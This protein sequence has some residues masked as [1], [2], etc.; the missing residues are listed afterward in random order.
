MRNLLIILFSFFLLSGYSQPPLPDWS[1]K[2]PP[3]FLRDAQGRIIT[4]ESGG[5]L[6]VI[7]VDTASAQLV[8]PPDTAQSFEVSLVDIT[9]NLLTTE[10]RGY[11]DFDEA[12]GNAIDSAG[13]ADLTLYGTVTQGETGILGDCYSFAG[14]GNAGNVD[15]YFEFDESF[16]LSVWMKTSS[17][18][19]GGAGLI[20]NFGT[21]NRG[22]D[23]LTWTTASVAK[24][25]IAIRGAWGTVT[26]VG[27]TQVND[28]AWHFI[29]ASYNSD[30]DTL[31]IYVDGTLEDSDYSVNGPVYLSDCR[32]RI[33]SRY[34]Q[35]YYTGYIDQPI[36][37]NKELSQAE[38]TALHNSGSGD[39][40]PFSQSGSGDTLNMAIS[41]FDA[42]ADSFR[43]NYEFATWPASRTSDSIQF[44]FGIAD[45]ADYNDTTFYW[46]DLSDTTAYFTM[47]SGYN[48]TW[49]AVPNKD[50]VL[51]DSSDIAPPDQDIGDWDTILYQDWE[52]HDAPIYYDRD[53]FLADYPNAL[54]RSGIPQYR[55]SDY[56][57]PQWFADNMKDSIVIDPITGSKVLL[58]RY[59]GG[60]HEGY[61]GQSG[62]GGDYWKTPLTGGP[63]TEIYVSQNIL[64]K[65][66]W[67]DNVTSGG[68]LTP[69]I[70][71][72]TPSGHLG[73]Q[74][75]GDGFWN[76][77]I[78]D[79]Y[80]IDKGNIAFYLYNQQTTGVNGTLYPWG[81]FQ[82]TGGGLTSGMYNATG[83][84]IYPS[85]D[86]TWYNITVRYVANTHTGSTPNY[87]GILEGYVN[88]RLIEQVSGL[89]LITYP[90]IGNEIVN[91][92]IYQAFGGGAPPTPTRD[93]WS[94]NDD[95]VVFTYDVSVDVPR[96]NELSEPGR[97]LNLPNW[98]KE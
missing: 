12:S 7:N 70:E 90:D 85:T 58:L 76:G 61:D 73:E 80:S 17:T 23:L 38:V 64:L 27:T 77:V 66:G 96:G 49:T 75:Y 20:C 25:Q 71:G 9:S 37:W 56:R 14:G 69:A 48:D 95:I 79:W 42:R 63:Y 8:L 52:D 29:V 44:A 91:L 46:D 82:P 50:T 65:P 53:L 89:Y 33:A 43:V 21:I 26:S 59:A 19:A 15:T 57:S 34:S 2:G 3:H 32:F 35:Y 11:W 86:S 60:Y 51:I 54:T 81:D 92:H 31:K 83:K 62:R 88:G 41:E 28:N 45:T 40:W 72:G 22:W 13:T 39:T 68:K 93:E 1:L 4:T 5:L 97:I 24:P 36:A 87:D 30:D 47:W 74:H 6:A 94:Y 10:I 55:A 84:F 98:P 78:W 18:T 16:S 67:M